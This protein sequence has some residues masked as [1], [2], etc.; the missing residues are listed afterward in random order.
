MAEDNTTVDPQAGDAAPINPQPQAGT[1]PPTDPQAGDS[2]KPSLSAADYERMIAELRK[3]SA[4]HRT[5]L[6][7]FEDEEKARSDAQLTEQQ[8]KDKQLAD[9]QKAHDDAIRQHQEYKV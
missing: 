5:K 4:S 6:K 1:T 7:K 3:E 2:Q 9:L 8:K